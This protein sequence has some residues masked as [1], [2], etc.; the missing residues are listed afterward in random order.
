MNMS[1]KRG[2]KTII[3]IL[4]KAGARSSTVQDTRENEQV[5]SNADDSDLGVTKVEGVK[6]ANQS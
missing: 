4:E 5:E 1:I 2:Y 3:K 6:S